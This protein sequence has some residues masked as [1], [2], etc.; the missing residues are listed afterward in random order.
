MTTVRKQPEG[1]GGGGERGDELQNAK[2]VQTKT[3]RIDLVS[4][5]QTRGG[6]RKRNDPT[7]S[8]NEEGRKP[9]SDVLMMTTVGL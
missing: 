1:G 4:C 9:A 8:G 5:Q 7:K 3:G 2:S 6:G